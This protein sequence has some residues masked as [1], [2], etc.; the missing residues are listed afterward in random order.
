MVPVQAWINGAAARNNC[1]NTNIAA[2][3][4]L[5]PPAPVP[6]ALEPTTLAAVGPA[7]GYFP[8]SYLTPS[9]TSFAVSAG[10]DDSAASTLTLNGTLLSNHSG[11]VTITVGGE[12]CSIT[13]LAADGSSV[14]CILPALPAG[15]A[16]IMLAV[17]AAGY[18][19]MPDGANTAMIT[20]PLVVNSPSPARGSYH[21]G[22]VLSIAGSGF[23]AGPSNS[24]VQMA[25]TVIGST[26]GPI[27]PFLA[28]STN[29][30]AMVQLPRF[31]AAVAAA[32]RQLTLQ[33]RVF[34]GASNITVATADVPY[35]LDTA[36]TP[37]VTQVT[38]TTMEPFTA[39]NLTVTWSVGA[40]AAWVAGA[41]DS[42]PAG[43]TSA[44]KV[45]LQ[46]GLNG[47]LYACGVVSDGSVTPE[48]IITTSNLN[49]TAGIY[50]ETVTCEVPATLPAASY[51]AWVF[52][53]GVG[54]GFAAAAV[55]VP[56]NVSSISRT[57]G[58]IAGGTEL[59]ITGTGE[60]QPMCWCCTNK[61]NLACPLYSTVK[62]AAM[63][64]L[65][66]SNPT[67]CDGRNLSMLYFVLMHATLVTAP[68]T[69]PLL[70]SQC[71]CAGFSP[72]TGAVAVSF[73]NSSCAVTAVNT[74]TVT[75]VTA[76]LTANMTAGQAYPA[77]ITPSQVR[78][79]SRHLTAAA[80]C[81]LVWATLLLAWCSTCVM[82]F[83]GQAPAIAACG[84]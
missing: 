60:L 27:T 61:H 8:S 73:D 62:D 38:P 23:A 22:V 7:C 36:Y 67:S 9:V 15:D 25:V 47:P 6:D 66:D 24:T 45:L 30:L 76:A 69:Q 54:C 74:T 63:R 28:S 32:T 14:S 49:S 53:D 64:Q 68:V 18:A 41:N 80:V 42:L 40:T 57:A 79:R 10:A 12:Q 3:T 55:R 11:E 78:Q 20:T 44:A 1:S 13:E 37:S 52:I 48:V 33:L 26:P 81:A 72:E 65:P 70:I 58:N 75:C 2:P 83:Q 71:P 16:T 34:D 84:A 59:I 39:A 4:T 21:G 82:H 19:A 5:T 31:K 51:D 56:L 43:T 46:A 17:A 35:I 50:Q 77:A 29:T